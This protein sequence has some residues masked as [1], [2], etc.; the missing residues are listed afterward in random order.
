M[1]LAF[2]KQKIPDADDVKLPRK[3][4]PASAG[5]PARRLVQE[6]LEENEARQDA[7]RVRREKQ[8]RLDAEA[9]QR[10]REERAQEAQ[11]KWS[12]HRDELRSQ[13]THAEAARDRIYEGG[14]ADLTT[15]ESALETIRQVSLRDAAGQVVAAAE[16]AIELHELE[17]QRR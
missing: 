9:Q 1:G 16:R 7:A 10:E 4:P 12:R 5:A 15:V 11:R 13:L 3:P 2:L 8:E 6:Q 14:S 17:R